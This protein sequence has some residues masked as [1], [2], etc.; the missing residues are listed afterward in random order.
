MHFGCKATSEASIP[1][2]ACGLLFTYKVDNNH[3]SNK[4]FGTQTILIGNASNIYLIVNNIVEYK[5]FIKIISLP[6]DFIAPQELVYEDLLARPLSRKDL[7]DDL[8]GVNSSIEI[9]Q[10]TRGGSWPTEK[11]EED[12]DLLDLAWHEREF[13][14]GNSYAY[15]IYSKEGNYIGCFYLYGMGVRTELTEEF[16][17]YDVDASWWVTSDAYGQGYYEKV[18]KALQQWLSVEFPFKEVYYSN[19]VLPL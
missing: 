17:S 13:R 2:S 16:L 3:L 7:A 11:L 4:G 18:Y 5:N 6:T 8:E 15:V 9:I 10:K 1:S 19:K 12:F 14:D